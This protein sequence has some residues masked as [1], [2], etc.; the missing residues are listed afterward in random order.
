MRIKRY[1][2]CRADG[3]VFTRVALQLDCAS[4]AAA[5]ALAAD[6]LLRAR[7]ISGSADLP[8][9]VHPYGAQG[10]LGSECV[11]D[12][13]VADFDSA[14][15]E[16]WDSRNPSE[17]GRVQLNGAAVKWESRINRRL[18][19]SRVERLLE[20]RDMRVPECFFVEPWHY[21]QGEND[22]AVWRVAVEWDSGL[23][24]SGDGRAV[25]PSLV[26]LDAQGNALDARVLRLEEQQGVRLGDATVDRAVFSV[27]T[28]ELRSAFVLLA[29][30][31]V[32]IAAPDC[33]CV[34]VNRADAMR[35]CY[36]E[37]TKDACGDDDAYRVWL[38]GHRASN[39]ELAAQSES[40][41]VGDV[42][43]S[44]VVPC[45]NSDKVYLREM[46][47][48]VVSQSYANWE[49]LLL[50]AS[51]EQPTV[52]EVAGEFADDRIRYYE[53]PGNAGIV[54]NTN[55]GI[56]LAK[57]NYVGFLDHDDTLEPHALYRY[58]LAI[59][60]SGARVLYCDEDSFH[61]NGD[62]G[63]PSFKPDFNRDL[64]YC[65]NCITHFLV[66]QKEAIAQIGVCAED[67]AG[68]QDYDLVLRALAAG[69]EPCHVPHILYHW[70]IHEGS[71]N[72]G[73]VGSKPYAIEAGRLAL[74]RHF[75]S[76]GIA[77]K[78]EALDE[79]FT[80]RMHY[81]LPD[82]RPMVSVII[83]TCDQSQMLE[84]CV[85]SLFGCTYR[86]IEVILVENGSKEP[87][88]E[89][90][91]A[92][93]QREHPGRVK[94][95]RWEKGFNYSALINY[96]VGFAQGEYLLLLNNDTKVISP[97]CI[98]EML[99]YLQRPEVGVVG[100]K[101]YFK[102]GL[103]QHA[104]ML[105]G[106]YDA[107]VHVHQFFP[108]G[109]AGYQARAVRPG[110]FSAVT[111]ACQMVKRAVFD[112]VGGYDEEFVVGFND[113]DFCLRVRDAGYLVV[114]T[115][116]A[117]LY[118]YEFVSRG[119]EAVDEKKQLRWKKEQAL[120]MQKW[121]RYFDGRDPFSNPNLKRDNLYF[122]LGE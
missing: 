81:S 60:E 58:A 96:G 18:R 25:S 1:E 116:Y 55:A 44:L 41:L 73:N 109:R 121:P 111:G 46:V 34:A 85:E 49:L 35:A 98:E 78:V 27:Q 67:V 30:D 107:L 31:E 77:G 117:E 89:E 6:G 110:N 43:F 54:G 76:L 64:L 122:A 57:G 16:V 26:C 115:P 83:P 69:F 51:A 104:G 71:S 88:T 50:D 66:V 19:K 39:E 93:L 74:Q 119:R 105:V 17:K 102:D 100:P 61:A 59:A 24:G 92:K 11:L 40:G 32:G 87:Q 52:R 108:P 70:R 72:N 36:W 14:V 99:G 28:A 21:Y 95:V 82:P 7:F 10:A 62:Y 53:L 3:R 68:A 33:C 94:V 4:V 42:Q 2:S 15:V 84:A 113:A 38:K 90:L 47:S 120:F 8:C 65:H 101:L 103:V 86:E 5:G 97:D 29:T 63:Q 12:Y 13:P 79:P 91:Y 37:E 106:P 80:Y 23:A 114:F 22:T 75:E 56:E 20:C 118:H 112:E 9:R 48:S 45:F